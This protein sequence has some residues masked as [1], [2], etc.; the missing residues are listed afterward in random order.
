MPRQRKVGLRV[1]VQHRFVES[2]EACDPRLGWREGVHPQNDTDT[3]WRRRRGDALITYSRRRCEHRLVHDPHRNLG[4]A[5]K[6]TRYHCR[7]LEDLSKY[8][9]A[10]QRLAAGKKPDLKICWGGQ[11]CSFARP[12]WTIDAG[13][14]S[15]L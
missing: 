10:V 11:R 12:A 6:L 8:G 7:L 3:M 15:Q 13:D 4:P 14:V 9:V 5:V 2:L 1:E